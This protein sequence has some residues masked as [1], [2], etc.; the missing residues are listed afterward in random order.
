MGANEADGFTARRMRVVRAVLVLLGVVC[1]AMGGSTLYELG[2]EKL[3][4]SIVFLLVGCAYLAVAC[5]A[6]DPIARL[7]SLLFP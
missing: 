1:L 4:L 6:S 2:G 7:V 3:W 5:F